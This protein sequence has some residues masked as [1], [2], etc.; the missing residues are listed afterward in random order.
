VLAVANLKPTATFT[1][2]M[3]IN[4]AVQP[5][6]KTSEAAKKQGFKNEWEKKQ[7]QEALDIIKK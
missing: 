3:G 1:G 2:T 7:V 4:C 5:P 6:L